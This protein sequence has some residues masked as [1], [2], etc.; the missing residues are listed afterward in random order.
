MFYSHKTVLK[1]AIYL[2]K[3]RFDLLNTHFMKIYILFL[4]FLNLTF[5]Q[6][7][8]NKLDANGKKD[9]PWKGF[10]DESKRLRFEGTFNHGVE[11]GIFKFYDDTKA[12]AVI[13][14]RTFSENGTVAENIFYDQNKNIVSQGKTIN[15]KNEGEWR[16]YHKNSKDIQTIEIYKNGKLFGNRKVFYV[17]NV[18]AEEAHYVDGKRNGLLKIY[19]NKGIVMEESNFK[20]DLYHGWAIFRLPNGDN[21]SQGNYTNGERKG[22]WQIFKNGKLFKTEKYPIQRKFAKKKDSKK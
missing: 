19:T 22:V 9:G 10:F 11:T 13:A 16:Y 15:R 17:G 1:L 7:D 14:T 12:A 6:T 8:F 21:G 4:L 2:C 18:I 20:N 3:S 5:A